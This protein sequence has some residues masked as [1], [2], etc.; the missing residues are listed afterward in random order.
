M[1]A[2]L[3]ALGDTPRSVTLR[4]RGGRIGQEQRGPVWEDETPEWIGGASGGEAMF[5]Q[6]QEL[7]FEA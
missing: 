6:M 7:S 5:Q 1:T 2:H 4:V 3:V